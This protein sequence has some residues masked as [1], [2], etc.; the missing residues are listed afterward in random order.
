MIVKRIRAT[1]V[2]HKGSHIADLLRY[3][4]NAPVPENGAQKRLEQTVQRGL[5]CDELPSQILEMAALA[6]EVTR[7]KNP[8]NHYVLSWREGE[9][10]TP[11]QVEQ[12]VDI[13]VDHLGLTGCQLVGAMH[14]DTNN[15]HLHLAINKVDPD[16]CKVRDINNRFDI[17]M[18]HEAIAKIEHAQGWMPEENALHFV[19]EHGEVKPRKEK[20]NKEALP[21]GALDSEVRSGSKSAARIA[22]ERVGNLFAEVQSW[23]ELHLRLKALNMA[24]VKDGRGAKVWCDGVA[25][26]ASTVDRKHGGFNKLEKR[27][28]R[29][30][31]LMEV[32]EN[33]YFTH[34]QATDN[35]LDIDQLRARNGHGL[36]KLSEC[37][38]AGQSRGEDS[39]LLQIN[40]RI[41]RS[42]VAELRRQSALARG[43]GA[44]R[45]GSESGLGGRGSSSESGVGS[46]REARSGVGIAGRGIRS[47]IASDSDLGGRRG[48]A[49]GTRGATGSVSGINPALA[50]KY[51]REKAEW[52]K[53]KA[54]AQALLKA[55]HEAE[56]KDLKAQ[57]G[58]DRER[59][60]KSQ[61]WRGKGGALN[62]LRATIKE[63]HSQAM[64]VLKA[65]HAA[66]RKEL[67]NHWK[68]EAGRDV[69]QWL[70]QR[71]NVIEA[72]AWRYRRV[73]V[74]FIIGRQSVPLA[75][76]DVQGYD[77]IHAGDCIHY[78]KKN[79]DEIA[80]TD[81]GTHI[82]VFDWR[83]EA[84][85]LDALMVAQAK[86]G[87]FEV[88]GD[89]EFKA[90][91]VALAA[92][93]NLELTNPE[94]LPMLESAKNLLPPTL[95]KVD[96]KVPEPEIEV[97]AKPGPAIEVEAEPVPEPEIEIDE[98]DEPVPEPEI[99]QDDEQ[100]DEPERDDGLSM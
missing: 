40:A 71:G 88:T 8:I 12:A 22:Q 62:A 34:D 19:D 4:T 35:E 81:R 92:K 1:K 73:T 51:R 38:L 80:F 79:A 76:V 85:L 97:A 29:F 32:K 75:A 56:V 5:M 63:D 44:G 70:E 31:A 57:Q 69:R 68:W 53:L 20:K 30:T 59:L 72:D 26:K 7:S 90:R 86:W 66:Q 64:A 50:A 28:G 77:S 10:P 17:K 96:A 95:A 13:F 54:D 47:G 18:A 67:V 48:G 78:R 55:R 52:N 16:T 33:D 37:H 91:C 36:R 39:G 60:V 24:Y 23:T 61:N 2:K 11:V 3:I 74:V 83:N 93:H 58:V 98:A 27:L 84:V 87:S 14:A 9:I 89:D 94:L 46:S 82:T 21:Q 42:A 25:L 49:G 65:A 43:R 99:D 6:S 15:R 45:S 100:P 41:G